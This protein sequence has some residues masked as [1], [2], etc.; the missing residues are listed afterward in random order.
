MD[1]H[2]LYL[3]TA[4]SSSRHINFRAEFGERSLARSIRDRAAPPQSSLLRMLAAFDSTVVSGSDST[5]SHKSCA[6]R[7]ITQAFREVFPSG[8]DRQ[9]SRSPVYPPPPEKRNSKA[10]KD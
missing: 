8:L 7:K 9:N 10:V 2:R 6:A 4:P 3:R 1:G 5:I